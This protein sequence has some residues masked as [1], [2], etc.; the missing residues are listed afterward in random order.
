MSEMVDKLH[1]QAAKILAAGSNG[2]KL[3]ATL[4]EAAREIETLQARIAVLEKVREEAEKLDH[5]DQTI[6]LE[7]ALLAVAEFEEQSES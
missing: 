5:S 4:F 3:K 7:N 6:L 2:V 1:E